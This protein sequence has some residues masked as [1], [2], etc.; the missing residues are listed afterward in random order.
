MGF[1]I[2]FFLLPQMLENKVTKKVG[3]IEEI[4]SWFTNVDNQMEHAVPLLCNF[5]V[6]SHLTT[7]TIFFFSLRNLVSIFWIILSLPQL[8]CYFNSFPEAQ[9]SIVA[10]TL[11][12]SQATQVL[13]S[14]LWYFPITLPWTSHLILL[15]LSIDILWGCFT[16]HYAS[17]T[18]NQITFLFFF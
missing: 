10:S 14:Q 17:V 2:L 13:K 15:R 1:I 5:P 12:L 6:I 11:T 8:L 3:N 18:L 9:Y 7:W 16:E 4:T